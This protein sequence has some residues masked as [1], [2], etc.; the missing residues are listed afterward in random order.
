MADAQVR[1]LLGVAD[2]RQGRSSSSTQ[3]TNTLAN[4]LKDVASM[5]AR[6]TAISATSYTPA[7]LDTMTAN[8][9][10]YAIRL[11]DDPGGI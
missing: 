2:K 4:N 3:V 5:R 11:N 9:M 10:A 1:N 6:L 7:R 8:D